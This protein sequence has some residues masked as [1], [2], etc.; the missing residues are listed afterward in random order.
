VS[1]ICSGRTITVTEG[2]MLIAHRT[3]I[4]VLVAAGCAYVMV[5]HSNRM[6]HEGTSF[7]E[8]GG[9]TVLVMCEFT[10][11]LAAISVALY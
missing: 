7:A 4:A 1:E 9:L 6:L 10:A 8:G 2:K 3:L 11:A 5:R